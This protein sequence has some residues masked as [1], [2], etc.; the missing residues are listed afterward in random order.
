MG[1]I[2]KWLVRW[3][4][5]LI[6]LACVAFGGYK[7]VYSRASDGVRDEVLKIVDDMSIESQWR[8]EVRRYIRQAHDQAFEAAL[9]VKAQLGRKFNAQVYVDELFDRVV[10]YARNQGHDRLADTVERER[11]AFTLDVKEH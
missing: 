8:P 6:I 5:S 11:H 4:I 1:K 9:N 7:Y 2:Q 10:Q 3:L